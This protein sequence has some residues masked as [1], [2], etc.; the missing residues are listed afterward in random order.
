[1]KVAIVGAGIAGLCCAY[2]LHPAHAVTVFEAGAHAGGHTNTVRVRREGRDLAVDTGFIVFNERNYPLFC[3]LLARLGVASQPAPMSFSV[4]CDRTG[5][6]YGGESI[7]GVFAQPSN[8]FR[9][10]FLRMIREIARLGRTGKSLLAGLDDE[11]TLGDLCRSGRFSREMVDH[12]LIPMGAAI[13]SAP[14]ESMMRF[15]ARSFFMFFDQ[16]GMLDL[17]ER[18]TWRTIS[19]GARAYVARIVAMLG[20]RCRIGCPVR[21]VSRTASGVMVRSAAG[22]G[23]FDE[24]ILAL[25]AD[26]ALAAIPALCDEGY[27]LEHVDCA[28]LEHGDAPVRTLQRQIAWID[29]RMRGEAVAPGAGSACR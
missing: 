29:A 8:L 23:S 13:W 7:R 18:P 21:S 14:R 6:E 22:E 2:L 12:Y 19:G 28:G 25:H 27:T 17:R 3:R 9:P 10:S 4:R 16:H 24:V 11:T 15:P 5:L 26:Q 1:M 20:E